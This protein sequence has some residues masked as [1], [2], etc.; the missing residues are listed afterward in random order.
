MLDH[1]RLMPAFFSCLI[2]LVNDFLI[3]AHSLCSLLVTVFVPVGVESRTV[4]GSRHLM[5]VNVTSGAGRAMDP[6]MRGASLV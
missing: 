2:L 3:D 1:Q 6:R 5:Q 4:A